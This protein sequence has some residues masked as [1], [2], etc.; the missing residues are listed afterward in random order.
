MQ[1]YDILYDIFNLEDINA[2]LSTRNGV[3]SAEALLTALCNGEES[4]ANTLN[5]SETTYTRTIK[6][7][8]PDKPLGKLRNYLLHKY[9]YKL[10]GNCGEV[11]EDTGF[12]KNSARRDGLNSHC[13]TCCL[14]TR[15]DYQKTYQAQVRALKLQRTPSWS[16]TEEIL[17]YY[18]KCPEGHHV[19]HIIPLQ[20]KTVSGLHVLNN[21][22]YLSANDNLVKGNR[23]T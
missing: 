18:A 20:G 6:Y 5:V 2:K 22:Q 7:L 21:L 14:E 13:K 4:V 19:D 10:C 23:F 1:L 9:A 12:S 11:K 8:W 3:I 17:D 16:E 15:R